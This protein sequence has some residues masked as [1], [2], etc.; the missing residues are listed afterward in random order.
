[1]YDFYL[2]IESGH[3]LLTYQCQLVWMISHLTSY[4]LRTCTYSPLI[5]FCAENNNNL[6]QG[7]RRSSQNSIFIIC[8]RMTLYIARSDIE[9]EKCLPI[10]ITNLKINCGRK[11][12]LATLLGR[13]VLDRHKTFKH[14][15][16]IISYCR[17]IITP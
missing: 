5:R 14:R 3:R 6:G 7:T 1:M 16:D 13:A 11:V 4:H 9:T 10:T 12:A 2:S 15:S 8:G 17:Q